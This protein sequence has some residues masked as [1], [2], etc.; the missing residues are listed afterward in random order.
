MPL[1]RNNQTIHKKVDTWVVNNV[2][3]YNF[4]DDSKED[5]LL[6]HEIHSGFDGKDKGIVKLIFCHNT[7][8]FMR[9]C[10]FFEQV[11]EDDIKHHVVVTMYI[12]TAENYYQPIGQQVYR[13]DT[14][15]MKLRQYHTVLMNEEK[16]KAWPVEF[17]RAPLEQLH[18]KEVPF[19]IRKQP[20]IIINNTITLRIELLTYLD[21][22]PM[23]PLNSLF[24]FTAD[25]QQPE[26]ILQ[27]YENRNVSGDLT[28]KIQDN[29]FRAHKQV[30][31]QRGFALNNATTEENN[32]FIF[33]D[34][35]PEIFGM[36][37]EFVYTGAIKELDDF[38]EPLLE[39]ADRFELKDLKSSCEKSLAENYVDYNNFADAYVLAKRCNAPELLSYAGSI[40]FVLS[41]GLD[42]E[43]WSK[44]NPPTTE[45]LEKYLLPMNK[46]REAEGTCSALMRRAQFSDSLR[47]LANKFNVFSTN[48]TTPNPLKI[49]VIDMDHPCCRGCNAKIVGETVPC[50]QCSAKY[51]PNCALLTGTNSSGAFTRCCSRRRPA[52]PLPSSIEALKESIIEE[53]KNSLQ[54][55]IVTS[56]NTAI[57]PIIQS[58]M[59]QQISTLTRNLEDTFNKQLS[60][61]F[62]EQV[63]AKL[64]EVHNSI[65][66]TASV[67]GQRG[68]EIETR[69]AN[70][71]QD[72]A[73]IDNR[74]D[75]L[76]KDL[77]IAKLS[78][79][80][81]SRS[82]EP[83]L[84]E[85]EDG[86]KR[87]K[88]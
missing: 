68:D 66:A 40:E 79:S 30:L 33:S 37:L 21:S 49:P 84:D 34:I 31:D 5:S 80:I 22:E 58:A 86:D 32:I 39:A 72:T 53:L 44:N 88:I 10:A 19:P 52:S 6:V 2:D 23:C 85:I 56:V 45:Q 36:L 46:I 28:I 18:E 29:E 8:A 65:A 25:V 55:I 38:A 57:G 47:R 64:N 26:W 17:T 9:S 41:H 60:S 24:G 48:G 16:V 70:L 75:N 82:D 81:S 12:L 54:D 4:I 7:Q 78:P 15:M 20:K 61:A 76:K 77:K 74:C 73:R 35:S 59:Q 62:N 42:S 63:D 14:R 50:P 67:L 3:K 69:L 1:Q 13:T 11:N 83:L 51:H 71:D 27:L 43:R 87:K